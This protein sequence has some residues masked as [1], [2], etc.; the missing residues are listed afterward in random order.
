MS[1]SFWTRNAETVLDL[2]GQCG[3][4]AMPY[5]GMWV[6]GKSP[7]LEQALTQAEERGFDIVYNFS[8]VHAVQGQKKKHPEVCCQLPEGKRFHLCPSYRGPLLSE[9]L[10]FIARGFAFHP[11]RWVFLDCEVH[12]SSLEHIA[13]C[14]RCKQGRNKD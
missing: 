13:Q 4:T 8:P 12:W 9:H 5:F 14:E 1:Q 3:F 11:A 10:D 6:R 7:E 2:L